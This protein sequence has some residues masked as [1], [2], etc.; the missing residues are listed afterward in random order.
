MITLI[1]GEDTTASRNHYYELKQ[2]AVEPLILDGTTISL[3]DLQQALSGDDLF[4]TARDIFIENL[5][6]K[7]KSPK[8]IEIL[9]HVLV[10]AK[11]NIVVWESKEL[12]KKQIEGFGKATVKQFKIPSTIFALLDGLK[13]ENGKEL[14]ELF[15]KTLLDKD[16]EFVL[17]MLQRQVRMLL[18][19]QDTGTEQISEVSRIAPWQRGKLERQAKLFTTEQLMTLHNGLFTLE[20]NMKTGQLSQ[21]LENEIDFLLLS[22]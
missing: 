18:A 8:D 1:Y 21:S 4:G 13:P 3:T 19:L 10:N 20:K 14:F 17:V 11:A 9:Q 22:L 7:R 15:H 6:S 2:H 5:I 16:P 12:T